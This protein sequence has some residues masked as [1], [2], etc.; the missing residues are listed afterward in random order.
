MAENAI[1]M[2]KKNSAEF[3]PCDV[4]PLGFIATIIKVLCYNIPMDRL[5]FFSPH[6]RLDIHQEIDL[7]LREIIKLKQ[8]PTLIRLSNK[9]SVQ[10]VMEQKIQRISNGPK[11]HLGP[12]CLV[13]LWY[14]DPKIKWFKIETKYNNH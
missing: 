9:A 4:S 13:E 14:N 7:Q 10:Y 5:Y 12:R 8:K 6:G 1:Q 11:Y 2:N 3:Q